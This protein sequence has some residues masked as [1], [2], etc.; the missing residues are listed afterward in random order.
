MT[1]P[2]KG[3]LALTLAIALSAAAG[4][5]CI[6]SRDRDFG[7]EWTLADAAASA[8]CA[9]VPGD[10]RDEGEGSSTNSGESVRAQPHSLADVLELDA[11]P[12][13][14]TLPA[15]RALVLARASSGHFLLRVVQV[16]PTDRV[17][18]AEIGARCAGTE[19]RLE[20]PARYESRDGVQVE[21]RTIKA[22]L[23]KDTEGNLVLR[24]EVR[25]R[26]L[27]VLDLRR[28]GSPVSY[29]RFTRRQD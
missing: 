12:M 23:F 20:I 28:G 8:G 24:R 15:D 6:S 26:S 25:D 27:G 21:R 2:R 10:Y 18:L 17:T 3:F 11:G 5:G 7:P 1:P 19:L 13:A 4:P 22:S 9:D 29:Y 14:D 16:L